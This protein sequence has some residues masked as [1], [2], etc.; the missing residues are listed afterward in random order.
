R[1]PGADY[2][3][4]PARRNVSSRVFV[5]Y[6]HLVLPLLRDLKDT[7]R[8][9]KFF[10]EE[11]ITEILRRT[12][13]CGLAFDV[14][15][16]LMAKL[17]GYRVAEVPISWFDSIKDSKIKLGSDSFDM[18]LAVWQFRKHLKQSHSVSSPV[19]GDKLSSKIQ[20]KELS[21][22]VAAMKSFSLIKLPIFLGAFI[23]AFFASP[24]KL[25]NMAA[26]IEKKLHYYKRL[27]DELVGRD[28][29]VVLAYLPIILMFL[30]IAFDN[31][32]QDI[33]TKPAFTARVNLLYKMFLFRFYIDKHLAS[34]IRLAER[35]RGDNQSVASSPIKDQENG[36]YIKIWKATIVICLFCLAVREHVNAV[37][38]MH[39]TWATLAVGF[40]ISGLVFIARTVK[41]R[42]VK[43]EAHKPR[44]PPESADKNQEVAPQEIL[45]PPAQN[46]SKAKRLTRI[47]E[48]VER[49]LIASCWYEINVLDEAGPCV[50]KYDS[51]D[52]FSQV[53]VWVNGKDWSVMLKRIIELPRS[54]RQE[55]RSFEIS[56]KAA[57][58][59]LQ[60]KNGFARVGLKSVSLKKD[61]Y[62][63][64]IYSDE[65]NKLQLV[66]SAEADF[67][68]GN[69]RIYFSKHLYENN[70]GIEI[71]HN[72][73]SP[74]YSRVSSSPVTHSIGSEENFFN[75]ICVES[76]AK[77]FNES[78]DIIS[79]DIR[80]IRESFGVVG[81][82]EEGL[83]YFSNPKTVDT[84]S[85]EIMGIEAFNQRTHKRVYEVLF[86][87]AHSEAVF[88]MLVK[89][90]K[91]S[92]R[93]TMSG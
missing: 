69:N 53:Q 48:D 66:L 84:H 50:L 10:T 81:L 22:P 28:N 73:S 20:R 46:K 52:P 8:G 25:N 58:K 55:Y 43:I 90:V 9:C 24:C 37:N 74:V 51:D 59:Q 71:I 17:L 87:E 85:L 60:I 76:L 1:C 2:Y 14:E 62:Q 54:H 4:V 38:F 26:Y 6:V 77:D 93:R 41:A 83:R 33:D 5:E 23:S 31:L 91:E 45:I 92:V 47:A 57:K 40:V 35:S 16:L 56:W 18:F 19:S 30:N 68:L 3:N 11:A 34:V 86:N 61:P 78:A 42:K 65:E 32:R 82:K 44:A 72:V 63:G 12:T 27:A 64:L 13:Y 7:Q 29:L 15:L 21:S 67:V 36:S 39:I 80:A 75:R 49:I 79:G 89:V 88:S 70:F